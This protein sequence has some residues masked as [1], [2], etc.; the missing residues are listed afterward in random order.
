[1]K[2]KLK[3]FKGVVAGR[4]LTEPDLMGAWGRGKQGLVDGKR[5]VLKGT[6]GAIV[7]MFENPPGLADEFLDDDGETID[8]AFVP[9]ACI[10]PATGAELEERRQ[11]FA[12][13]FPDP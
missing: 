3:M 7:E 13:L 11:H 10:R 6:H 5:G 2:S 1:M 12:V 4:D 9:E 8:V